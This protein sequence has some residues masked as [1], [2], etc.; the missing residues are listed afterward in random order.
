MNVAIFANEVIFPILLFFV[1]YYFLVIRPETQTLELDTAGANTQSLS[2][3]TLNDLY[4]T[5]V[6]DNRWQ[7][8]LDSIGDRQELID[9]LIAIAASH[10]YCLTS[11]D[12]ESSIQQYT[13]GSQT[14]YVC[15]PI[16]C[17][18]VS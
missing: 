1:F 18:R 15:L 10:G 12:I 13:Q 9:K 16:G 3:D 2:T 6:Q 14:N 5:I 7:S 8:E 11:Q 4:D 17:W